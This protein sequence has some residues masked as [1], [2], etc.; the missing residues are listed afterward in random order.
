MVGELCS[1]CVLEAA[2]CD[3]RAI[4]ELA[5]GLVAQRLAK[6]AMDEY[7]NDDEERDQRS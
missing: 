2:G 7:P 3:T 4:H 1:R 6:L 5:V